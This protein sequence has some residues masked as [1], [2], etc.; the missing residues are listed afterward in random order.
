MRLTELALEDR[1]GIVYLALDRP[2][3]NEINP[4]LFDELAWVTGDELIRRAPEGVIV[5]G[6]GRHFSSGTD[7]ARLKA[8]VAQ[9]RLTP[10][11]GDFRSLSDLDCPV[12]AAVRGCCL[13]SGAELAMACGFRIAARNALFALP[14]TQFD[15]MPGCG[16]TVRLTGLVG[17][18]TAVDL[19]LTGRMVAA[20][21]ALAIGLIDYVTETA[22][23]L[24]AAESLI[25]CLAKHRRN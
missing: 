18:G 23:L 8:E 22:D 25:R 3:R 19:V 20:D 15:L 5:H 7:V 2:P 13:G 9:G 24:P 6:R 21:E 17:R 12:V 14:E 10:R 4:R 11:H 16:G 1:E